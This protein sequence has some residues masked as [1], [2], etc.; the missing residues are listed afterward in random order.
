MAQWAIECTYC[1][2]AF[3]YSEIAATNS[4]T[5][6]SDPFSELET[7]PAFPAMGLSL[8]CPNCKTTAV[9]KQHHLFYRRAT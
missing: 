2:F 4:Q 8:D 9:Y 1:G 7:R 6:M 5:R 3:T